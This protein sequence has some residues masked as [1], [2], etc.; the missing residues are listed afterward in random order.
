M[1]GCSLS[2]FSGG[3]VCG[4]VLFVESKQ[5]FGKHNDVSMGFAKPI[6]YGHYY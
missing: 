2:S 1:A 6:Y 3:V 4:L 5:M